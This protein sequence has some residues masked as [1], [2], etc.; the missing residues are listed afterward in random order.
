MNLINSSN[1]R[2]LAMRC[3]RAC[4][5]DAS[6]ELSNV[7][8]LFQGSIADKRKLLQQFLSN[9]ENLEKTN[10]WLEYT[11]EVEQEGKEAEELLTVKGMRKEGVSECLV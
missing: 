11:R 3:N 4:N 9:A 5:N 1:C 6:A 2:K 7:Q 10:A 8:A